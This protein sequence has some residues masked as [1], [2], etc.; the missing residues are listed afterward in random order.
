M[1]VTELLGEA[2]R[3][4]RCMYEESWIFANQ[5]IKQPAIQKS[6]AKIEPEKVGKVLMFVLFV[7]I[8]VFLFLAENAIR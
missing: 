2:E 1:T 6:T 7:I 3:M 8:M 4:Y 5:Y